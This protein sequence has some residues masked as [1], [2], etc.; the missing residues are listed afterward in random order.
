LL[1]TSQ[2]AAMRQPS[3]NAALKI[4]RMIDSSIL[5][6]SYFVT[7]ISCSAWFFQERNNKGSIF[8]LHEGEARCLSLES[9]H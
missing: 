6:S 5:L 4:V 3:P 8:M 7:S 9:S 2:P 1:I